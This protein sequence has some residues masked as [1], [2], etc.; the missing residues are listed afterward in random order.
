ML[1]ALSINIVINKTHSVPSRWLAGTFAILY[2]PQA[3]KILILVPIVSFIIGGLISSIISHKL[4]FEV[5]KLWHSKLVSAGDALLNQSKSREALPLYLK[6]IRINE[7]YSHDD[8]LRL[9]GLEKLLSYYK[10]LNDSVNQADVE[11][12]IKAIKQDR[13]IPRYQPLT[14]I[15]AKQMIQKMY[16][17]PCVSLGVLVINAVVIGLILPAYGLILFV[18]VAFGF[19]SG[20]VL[21]GYLELCS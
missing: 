14:P 5:V 16:F 13:N 15:E 2:A 18:L 7:K 19:V 12:R 6:A 1:W 10:Y 11:Q 21:V 3:I 20:S 8:S 4:K 9:N 17:G